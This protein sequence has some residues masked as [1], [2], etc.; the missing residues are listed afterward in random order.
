[1]ALQLPCVA[2]AVGPKLKPK[3]AFENVPPKITQIKEYHALGQHIESLYCTPLKP[4]TATP[5]QRKIQS[6]EFARSHN[7]MAWPAPRNGFCIGQLTHCAGGRHFG[8]EHS[9]AHNLGLRI[10]D[11]RSGTFLRELRKARWRSRIVRDH[12]RRASIAPSPA[13]H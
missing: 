7:E 5:C 13:A 10:L 3:T 12:A 11:S 9:G 6:T 2:F 4:R 1:M 8:R